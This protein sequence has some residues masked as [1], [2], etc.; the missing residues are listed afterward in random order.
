MRTHISIVQLGKMDLPNTLIIGPG[1]VKGFLHLGAIDLLERNGILDN[2]ARYVGV[3][4]GALI[5]LMLTMGYTIPEILYDAIEIQDLFEDYMKISRVDQ[6]TAMTKEAI[7]NGGALTNKKVKDRLINNTIKK[8]GTVLTLKELYN[9]TGIIFV[10]VTLNVSKD[11]VE[12]LSWETEPDLSCVDAVMMSM[13]IPLIFHKINYKGSL[14]VDG[15]LGN[16]FP[17]D[18]Y[19]NEPV[20]GLYIETDHGNIDESVYSYIFKVLTCSS[21]QIYKRTMEL[22]GTQCVRIC[23]KTPIESTLGTG[24]S[25]KDKMEMYYHGYNTAKTFIDTGMY[26]KDQ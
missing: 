18:A 20:L 9:A 7:Q 21:V 17:V 22:A 12:Y 6:L 16:P 2:V 25:T 1:G 8:F 13:N 10:S 3:S 24:L 15:A 11:Q 4:V 5:S 23:L 14:Y 19:Q 26:R